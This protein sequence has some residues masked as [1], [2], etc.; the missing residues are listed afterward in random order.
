MHVKGQELPMHEPRGKVGVGLG[1]ATNEA[2]ADHLVGFHDPLFVNPESVPFRSVADLGITEPTGVLDLGEKK[3]RIWYTSERWNSAEKV[4]GLCFFGPAPRSL[5][6]VA[7][8]LTAVRAATGW[9]VTADE[10]LEVGER[11]VTMARVFNVREGFTRADDRLPDR[12]FTPLENG[13]L[14]GTAIARDDFEQALT[15]LYL[16]KG[17]DP[18]TGAPTEG[19]LRALGLAWTAAGAVGS[20][21]AAG[22]GA[23]GSAEPG[24]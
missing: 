4:L 13:A 11:A 21:A 14:A 8:V 18:V 5:I 19:R 16:L 15:N 23:A 7:D 24:R 20:A 6:Q 17:W 10:L 2:G 22:G 12:L 1:Y 3:V 9:D